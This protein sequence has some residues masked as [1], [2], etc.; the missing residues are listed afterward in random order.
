M[1]R[2]MR[3]CP[4]LVGP[5]AVRPLT[6]ALLFSVATSG[7]LLAAPARKKVP[8]AKSQLAKTYKAL[9]KTKTYAVDTKV[10]GGLSS[11]TDH[12]V[13]NVTVNETYGGS[14]FG[15]S[16]TPM[17]HIP[18]IQAYKM[19]KAGQGVI[20]RDGQWVR[21]LS[22]QTGVKMD[23]LIDFPRLILGE[24][25]RYAGSARWLEEEELA[26]Y[27][28]SKN[29]A[30]LDSLD[31]GDATGEPA[32]EAVNQGKTAVKGGLEK[33]GTEPMPRVLRVTAHPKQALG[34]WIKRVENSGCMRDG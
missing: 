25:M 33:E 21:I 29:D 23:R 27:F 20:S 2:R 32:R 13:S 22:T 30:D 14:V 15:A 24:A 6:L 19:P 4:F 7:F 34:I 18:S 8:S 16:R 9:L 28:K 11:T 3:S 5:L 12:Q 26:D 17:M 31:E 1:T 10:L